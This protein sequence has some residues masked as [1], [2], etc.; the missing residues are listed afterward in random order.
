VRI[1]VNHLTRMRGPRICVAGIDTVSYRYVRP[2][3]SPG[4]P[5]TRALLRENGGPFG[6]AALVDIGRVTAVPNAPEMEDHA[7]D[8]TRAERVSDVDDESYLCLADRPV[9]DVP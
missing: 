5:L 2:V 8:A 3:A 9:G 1:V 7:F 6:A 4:H